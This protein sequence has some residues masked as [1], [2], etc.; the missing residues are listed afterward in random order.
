MMV[1]WR[2]GVGGEVI[3]WGGKEKIVKEIRRRRTTESNGEGCNRDVAT[4]RRQ[5]REG[6]AGGRRA[7]VT[8]QNPRVGSL[9]PYII[10]GL[11]L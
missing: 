7:N 4:R 5:W 3:T 2:E 10:G 9:L 8:I 11:R 6:V 1:Q